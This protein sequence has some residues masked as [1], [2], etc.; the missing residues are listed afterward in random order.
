MA[1]FS[2]GRYDME[3]GRQN[4]LFLAQIFKRFGLCQGSQWINELCYKMW[5]PPILQ[6]M[7]DIFYDIANFAFANINNPSSYWRREAF[8]VLCTIWT[9]VYTDHST[10]SISISPSLKGSHFSWVFTA[11][12]QR[13]GVSLLFICY[14][15]WI[16]HY[17]Y[18]LI[19]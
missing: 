15:I 4:V 14:F 19:Q 11:F 2:E 7:N 18:L 13:C 9:R 3:K 17:I 16:H 1:P 6:S 8:Q 12:A 10:A 5:L